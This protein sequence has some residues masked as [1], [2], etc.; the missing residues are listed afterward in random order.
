MKYCLLRALVLVCLHFTLLT[1]VLA[2]PIEWQTTR[3]SAVEKAR[4][5]GKLILLLAGRESCFNCRFMK[6]VV[7]ES[8]DIRQVADDNYVYWFCEM[9][10]SEEWFN[11]AG[12]LGSIDRVHHNFFPN[13]KWPL[14]YA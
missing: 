5:S 10:T 2:A 12:G 4:N 8:D 11:Y 14:F 3:A 7:L 1:S 13:A 6:N 9:D